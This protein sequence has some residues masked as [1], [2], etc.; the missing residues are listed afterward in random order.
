MQ[1]HVNNVM[2]K[3]IY[4]IWEYFNFK[5]NVKHLICIVHEESNETVISSFFVEI[6]R[7]FSHLENFNDDNKICFYVSLHM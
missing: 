2:F 1:Q 7:K 3:E 5:S 4:D 6:L